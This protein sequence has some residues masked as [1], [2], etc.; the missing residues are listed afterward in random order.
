MTSTAQLE[1]GWGNN[2]GVWLG[3]LFYFC[4]FGD[5]V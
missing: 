4:K 3:L 2:A 1:C 5:G